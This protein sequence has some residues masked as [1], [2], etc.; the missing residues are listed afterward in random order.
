M[1]GLPSKN[2]RINSDFEVVSRM[3]YLDTGWD[4]N[5]ANKQATSFYHEKYDLTFFC[6]NGKVKF[7]D[8]TNS[9]AVVDTGLSLTTTETTT[10]AEYA[11][12]VY[13]T[14]PTD[15]LRQIRIGRGSGTSGEP[16]M[17]LDQDF[18]GRIYAFR[19]GSANVLSGTLRIANDT[20]FT[21]DFSITV[22]TNVTNAA[23]NG[24]G[25]IR[26]TTDADHTLQ[27]GNQ[28]LIASVDGT[29][30]AN[31]TWTIT[32]VD[33]TNFDLQ[34]STFS[35]SY[36]SGGTSTIVFT[37][38][39]PLSNTLDATV[40]D[41]IV[42]IV[43][44]ISSG[45]PKG[46]KVTFWQERMIVIGV[47]SDSDVDNATQIA[48]MSKFASARDLRNVITFG[49]TG[50]ASEEWVGKSGSLKNIVSTRD[51]LYYFKEGETYFSSVADINLSTGATAPQLLSNNY[52]CVNEN[53]A[54][55]LGSGV[56]AYLT[57][58]KR[59]M[60]IRIATDSGAA[61]V[62]PDEGFDQA[63]R[64]TLDLLDDDQSDS[65]MF[66]HKGK[67]LLYVQV[68]VDSQIITLI[69]DN[70]IGKWIPPDT[71]KVFSSYFEKEGILYATEKNDDTVFELDTGEED[72]GNPFESVIGLPKA[73]SEDG[74]TT[75]ELREMHLSGS[76]SEA[77][78]IQI[79]QIVN[80]GTPQKKTVDF[81]GLS[82]GDLESM[83]TIVM[84]GTAFSLSGN[85]YL[86]ASWEKRGGIYP[87]FGT[88]YQTILS[89]EKPF[90]LSSYSLIA[91]ALPRP[92]I[93]LT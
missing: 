36:T 38:I 44:D 29:T 20:P 51:Y 6:L 45:K 90:A 18:I 57:K 53:C 10:F 9:D 58:N 84:G 28:V 3:G 87:R 25:L 50:G 64:N 12:D 37:D 32:R 67:R 79:E 15:G 54:V 91:E 27:T 71:N 68:S 56:I 48:Y 30:E 73:E 60:A 93:T 74:R 82:F 80:N 55:D 11:G 62:F 88:L 14:N 22:Q 23:D 7:V 42:Y 77:A 34:D 24:S 46:S 13:L 63:I 2:V 35:N 76:I 69:Y 40:A 78:T 83:G 17:T 47:P 61:T 81:S 49:I 59:V 5:E 89:S 26:I 52:G 72:D 92:L 75:L 70:N 39:M 86:P 65:I 41:K 66:Y 21:E 1:V 16:T 19:V 31:G 43:N 4:L 85:E 8:H 33:A